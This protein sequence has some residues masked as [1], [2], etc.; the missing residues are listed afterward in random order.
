MQRATVP[1]ATGSDFCE[2]H[3]LCMRERI[4]GMISPQESAEYGPAGEAQ[5]DD[6]VF[7][8]KCEEAWRGG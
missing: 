2:I 6:D 7:E 3:C 1:S 4:L 8:Y 5:I